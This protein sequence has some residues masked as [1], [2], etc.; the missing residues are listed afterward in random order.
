VGTRDKAPAYFRTAQVWAEEATCPK[1][2]VGAVLVKDGHVIATGFNG[3]PPG[4][5]HCTDV[6][7]LIVDGRCERTVHAE[8]NAIAQAARHGHST[9]G[10]VLYCTLEPC[11]RCQMLLL[12]C[13]VAEWR[14]IEDH[15]KGPSLKEVKEGC[16]R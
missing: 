8:A 5:P 1:R 11:L 4:W 12:S 16:L 6:G 7:C 3:S 15:R 10:A 14:W 9:D 13:G 2:Q